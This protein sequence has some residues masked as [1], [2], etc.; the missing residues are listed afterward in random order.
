M[1]NYSNILWPLV[2]DQ[3]N[4]G[5]HQQELAFYKKKASVVGGRI[6]EIACG[7]GMILL[8]L[9][10][11]RSDAFGFDISE[12]MIELLQK[13]AKATNI[14]IADRVSIQNMIDFHYDFKFNLVFIPARS[15]LHL[16]TQRDQIS[17]LRNIHDHLENDGK[18]IIN[19]F[20]PNLEMILKNLDPDPPY[21]VLD[22]YMHP[23]TKEAI[24]LSFKQ[25][26]DITN[27]VQNITWCFEFAGLSHYTNMNV[28]WIYRNEFMLLSKFTGFDKVSLFSG[29]NE[30][31]YNG[32]DEMVW[33]LEK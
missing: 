32:Q 25:V 13:K 1:K 31:E 23:E 17:C 9:L 21:Q 29:F 18:L 15:F 6:L 26:N 24:K 3:Y 20:T 8:P 28:K 4:Q 14:D 5:R 30:K 19:F 10:V 7:T 12:Q 27:Q 33:I 11:Q 16:S 22:T 2:Y